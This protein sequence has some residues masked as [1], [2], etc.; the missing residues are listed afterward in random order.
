MDPL[1]SKYVATLE[2]NLK[3]ESFLQREVFTR[4]SAVV[5]P[6]FELLAAV[7]FGLRTIFFTVFFIP[8]TIL[9]LI[10]WLANLNKNEVVNLLLKISSI[11]QVLY[12]AIMT[13][14]CSVNILLGPAIGCISPTA[15][16]R[17]HILCGLAEDP[18]EKAKAKAKEIE[19]NEKRI[20]GFQKIA[21]MD[22]L[23]Q[24]LSMQV[25]N[26]LKEPETYKEYGLKIPSGILLYGPPGCGKTF[27]AQCLAEEMKANFM[28]I[29][30]SVGSKYIH[31]TAQNIAKIFKKA[32]ENAT[33]QNPFVL[34]FDEFESMVPSRNRINGPDS[35]YKDEE[36][37][38]FLQELQKCSSRNI[39]VIASTNHI[40]KIDEAV[41]RPGR[42]DHKIYIHF[43]DKSNIAA[44]LRSFLE[45]RPTKI[46]I[47]TEDDLG[48]LAQKLQGKNLSVSDIEKFVD[49]A[50]LTALNRNQKISIDLLEEESL[51]LPKL[52]AIPNSYKSFTLNNPVELLA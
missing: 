27:I 31:E 36:V 41:L 34:I 38:Q 46:E 51:K 4:I 28:V 9:Y 26:S 47:I 5:L 17:F 3:T 6:V 11:E 22:K 52:R 48:K 24:S 16:L 40:D 12:E 15:N 39:I 49:D 35:L 45:R 1:L 18:N 43:P 7:R 30:S 14:I 10:V 37:N 44:L 25:I 8:K 23:K 21:G 33:P 42:F 32:A 20:R 13:A 29:P 2:Y 19:E 50:A